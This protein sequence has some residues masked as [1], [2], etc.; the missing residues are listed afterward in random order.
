[1]LPW[2]TKVGLGQPAV[3]D[4][5]VLDDMIKRSIAM[6]NLRKSRDWWVITEV[7]N[8]LYKET[9]SG[10]GKRDAPVEQLMRGNHR[11]ELIGEISAMFDQLISNGKKA[12]AQLQKLRE[13]K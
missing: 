9:V 3:Q 2:P 11:L 10:L 4:E 5:K 7:I 13:K 1:M 12:A 8:T 6:D